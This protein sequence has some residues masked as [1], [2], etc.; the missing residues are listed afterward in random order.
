M[1]EVARSARRFFAIAAAAFAHAGEDNVGRMSAALAYYSI[2][3]LPPSIII[4]FSIA[5]GIVG[6]AAARQHIQAELDLFA[7]PTIATAIEGFLR[8]AY[9]SIGGASTTLIGL[10]SLVFGG[11]GI[12]LE[13]RESL[14]AILGGRP[15]REHRLLRIVKNRTL[16]FVLVLAGSLLVLCLMVL[17]TVLQS[18]L[19]GA[20][21]IVPGG[22][23]YIGI[24]SNL[25]LFAIAW[26]LLALLYRQLPRPKPAWRDAW[27]GAALGAALFVALEFVLT[28]YLARLPSTSPLAATG[29]VF[30]LL[31]WVYFSAQVVYFGA[32][33]TK[34]YARWREDH[35]GS[36]VAR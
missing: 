21:P 16:A 5:A 6:R 1:S 8:L 14:H 7:G 31:V 3:A 28:F 32:E 33:F 17:S 36:S 35:S 20:D 26:P 19:S 22:R 18:L 29:S 9:R 24:A 4:A 12:F 10:V 15:P 30:A 27:W 25:V 23:V 11:S 2:F 34:S 13:L